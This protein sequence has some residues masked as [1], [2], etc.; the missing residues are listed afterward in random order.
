VGK[1]K[2]LWA[3]KG[4]VVSAFAASVADIKQGSGRGSGSSGGV[5][6]RYIDQP[7]LIGG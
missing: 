6:Q 5:V 2:N 4:L 1:Q 3:G 7:L